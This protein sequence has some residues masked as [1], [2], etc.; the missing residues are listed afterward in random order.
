VTRFAAIAGGNTRLQ[1]PA[2][3]AFDAGRNI[4]VTDAAKQSTP[5]RH[6]GALTPSAKRSSAT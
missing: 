1:Y 4:D 5:A 3:I 2:Q 6:H